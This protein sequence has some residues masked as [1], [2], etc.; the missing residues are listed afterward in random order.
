M[1]FAERCAAL[2]TAGD[3]LRHRRFEKYFPARTI[4]FAAGETLRDKRE[5]TPM[6]GVFS[7][8]VRMDYS[9]PMAMNTRLDTASRKG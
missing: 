1:R 5:H 3:R 9:L 4:Y 6:G 7:Y 2:P 8:I